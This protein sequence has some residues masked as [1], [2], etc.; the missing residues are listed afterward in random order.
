MTTIKERVPSAVQEPLALASVGVMTLGL[1]VG[2][3]LIT[4][5]IN[6]YLGLV[7]PTELSAVDAAIVIA[8]GLVSAVVGYLGWRGFMYFSS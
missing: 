1:T 4:L 8:L 6:V 2:Y 3:I 7:L 5:G